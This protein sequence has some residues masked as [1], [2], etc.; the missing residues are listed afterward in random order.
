MKLLTR[1]LLMFTTA[2]YGLRSYANA[3][4]NATAADSPALALLILLVIDGTD[5]SGF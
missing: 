1:T 5:E 3:R 4:R 2:S